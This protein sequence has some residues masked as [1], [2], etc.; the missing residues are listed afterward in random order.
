MKFIQLPIH[1]L[2]AIV[3]SLYYLF[4]WNPYKGVQSGK[5]STTADNS[6]IISPS[7]LSDL[8][9]SPTVTTL[10]NSTAVLISSAALLGT[11]GTRNVNDSFDSVTPKTLKYKQKRSSERVSNFEERL[12]TSFSPFYIPSKLISSKDMLTK[13]NG[14]ISMEPVLQGEH[15]GIGQ[16]NILTHNIV[17]GD[18]K[19]IKRKLRTLDLET[20]KSKS[21]YEMYNL[22]NPQPFYLE[23]PFTTYAK[24]EFH[25]K[26]NYSSN[27]ILM[28]STLKTRLNITFLFQHNVPRVDKTASRAYAIIFS[29]PMK[30]Q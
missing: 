6:T 20:V 30:N 19:N 9:T 2:G 17:G 10:L 4:L 18:R 26:V 14:V 23:D 29:M 13:K 3:L 8:I 12:K 22:V 11:A 28:V 5:S 15:K 25:I 1:N 16:S 27:F 7:D 21:P 24:G